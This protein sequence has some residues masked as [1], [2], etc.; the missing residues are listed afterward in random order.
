MLSLWVIFSE[1]GDQ[2]FKI[3]TFKIWTKITII[4][5]MVLLRF[6]YKGKSKI[7]CYESP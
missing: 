7:S 3:W 5:F 2:T 1:D 4:T 6:D